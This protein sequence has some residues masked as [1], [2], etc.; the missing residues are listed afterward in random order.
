MAIE[1]SYPNIKNVYD[2][3]GLKPPTRPLL[4]I[5]LEIGVIEL[6]YLLGQ[7]PVNEEGPGTSTKKTL[8]VPSGTQQRPVDANGGDGGH[9]W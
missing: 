6:Q 4:L 5:F 1:R 7:P 9:R 2:S 8:L 3:D